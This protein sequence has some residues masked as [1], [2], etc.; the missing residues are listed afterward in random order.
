MPTLRYYRCL[1]GFR[2]RVAEE[3]ER[4]RKVFFGNGA[5]AVVRHQP[6][7]NDV[8]MA[9]KLLSVYLHKITTAGGRSLDAKVDRASDEDADG[10]FM[11]TKRTRLFVYR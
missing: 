11:D 2:F 9:V 3:K 1:G 5:Q 8:S 4:H 10:F 7:I 6:S